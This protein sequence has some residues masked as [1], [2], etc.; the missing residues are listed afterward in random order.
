MKKILS[1]VISFNL[2]FMTSCAVNK[3]L[4]EDSFVQSENA[5]QEVIDFIVDVEEGRDIRV[6]Q[7]TDTQIIDSAQQRSDDRLGEEQTARWATEQM[8]NCLF[9]Y[10]RNAVERAQPDLII[11]TGDLVYGEFDDS[12]R[13]FKKLIAH[14]DGYGIPW[15]PIYGNHDNESMKGAKWQNEQ[16]M[17]AERFGQK[18]LEGS[19]R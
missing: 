10:I 13:S 16:L 15:A 6:L 19:G 2:L 5:S 8:D 4:G 7:L 1:F 18:I 11:I 17:S 9:K 12:G 3:S 14:M